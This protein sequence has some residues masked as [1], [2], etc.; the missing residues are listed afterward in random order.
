MKTVMNILDSKGNDVWRVAPDDTVFEAI[1][2]M[3]EKGVGALL[4]MNGTELV[5]VISERDYA[6]KVIL[7]GKSSEKTRVGEIMTTEV[8][9]APPEQTVEE[10]MRVMT[11]NRIRHLP[12]VRGG[13]V[14]GVLSI[15]DLVKAI[16]EEQHFTIKQ[17]EMY[18]TG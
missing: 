2:L 7:N 6:R 13:K 16:I 4:V 9:C 8:I 5:G 3:A 17:L 12:V 18:I 1:K 10:C 15:G 11:E 14:V